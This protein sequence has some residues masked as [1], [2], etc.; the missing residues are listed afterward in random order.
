MCLNPDNR[1]GFWVEIMGPTEGLN[2][3]RVFL[4]EFRIPFKSPGGQELKQL[5]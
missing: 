5:L 2:P 1:I 4:Q 3:D